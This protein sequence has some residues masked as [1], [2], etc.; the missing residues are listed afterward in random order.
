MYLCKLASSNVPTN[1]DDSAK[2]KS[3]F[4]ELKKTRYIPLTPELQ[5]ML[6]GGA[7]LGGLLNANDRPLLGAIRGAGSGFG[8]VGGKKGGHKLA[9]Y[10]LS[11]GSLNGFDDTSKAVIRSGIGLGGGVLGA[12]LANNFIKRTTE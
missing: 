1:K 4:K 10:L 11:Q 7:A 5:W 8:F 9:D 3:I 12:I 6:G 2:G